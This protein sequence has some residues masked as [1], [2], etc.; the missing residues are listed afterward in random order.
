MANRALWL[1]AIALL[2]GIGLILSRS[3]QSD[4]PPATT[5]GT[6]PTPIADPLPEDPAARAQAAAQAVLEQKR[7]QAMSD[8]V[9]TLHRYLTVLSGSD[10]A[11]AD[12]FWVGKRPPSPSHEADL[13]SLQGL[14][15]LRIQN[16][17]PKPMDS[18]PVPT[19]F[20]IPVDLRASTEGQPLR[21][22]RGWYRLRSATPGEWR[23][24]SASVDAVTR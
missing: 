23:I 17:T 14:R 16:S 1:F 10:R 19:A 22:Y 11:A 6:M 20:E 7:L 18:E 15:E 4:S 2:V 24:T 5:V 9:D 12:A 3:C 8:A 13:R 21:R